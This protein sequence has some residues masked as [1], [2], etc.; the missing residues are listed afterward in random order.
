MKN[1][2]T[3]TCAFNPFT[4]IHTSDSGR[5]GGGVPGPMPALRISTTAI[6]TSRR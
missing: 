5:I 4:S 2:K 1:E 6:S 3:I